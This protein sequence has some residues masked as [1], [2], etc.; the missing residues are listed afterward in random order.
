MNISQLTVSAA[1]LVH[2]FDTVAD[3]T[4]A[5]AATP[6]HVAAEMDS[7]ATD[8]ASVRAA[9]GPV[10]PDGVDE[11]LA[12]RSDDIANFATRASDASVQPRSGSGDLE[13]LFRMR[14]GL[15]TLHA[16]AYAASSLALEPT[17][18]AARGGLQAIEGAGRRFVEPL[19]ADGARQLE[20]ADELLSTYRFPGLVGTEH[21]KVLVT[22]ETIRVQ[23]P[24]AAMVGAVEAQLAHL[25]PHDTATA[26]SDAAGS[27]AHRFLYSGDVMN[28]DR[29]Q[30]MAGM[31]ADL[32]G[33]RAAIAALDSAQMDA[34]AARANR[35][36][37]GEV[38]AAAATLAATLADGDHLDSLRA[39]LADP[40]TPVS[41]AQA[42]MQH[43]VTTAANVA[44]ASDALRSG[45]TSM[46][47]TDTANRS[48]QFA[49]TLLSD[50]QA[51]PHSVALPVS[52][53]NA[54]DAAY[55]ASNIDAGPVFAALRQAFAHLD[56]ASGAT[57]QVR[58]VLALADVARAQISAAA[59]SAAKLAGAALAAERFDVT[60]RE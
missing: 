24:A 14:S 8:A 26:L 5:G 29:R 45:V 41:I 19:V 4:F 58:E 23:S 39:Q 34:V 32:G 43:L 1:D 10:S 44:Q 40:A 55:R 36:L 16:A 33:A 25:L 15:A 53:Q 54:I 12:L 38:R 51:S 18:V 31:R 20:R 21:R 22:A 48:I 35:V 60:L 27:V 46:A 30:V 42:A 28:T 11:L 37:G 47:I 2:R 17:S 50:V 52:T 56:L 6:A 3:A 49:K 9:L 57:P 59:A 7:I 13:R